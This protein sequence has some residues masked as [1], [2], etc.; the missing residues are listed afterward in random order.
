VAFVLPCDANK[1]AS[2]YHNGVL[3]VQGT[4]ANASGVAGNLDVWA[5]SSAVPGMFAEIFGF[6]SWTRAL[7]PEEIR[8]LSA[9]TW[10]LLGKTQ[11]F[12]YAP[13]MAYRHA[14]IASNSS[15]AAAGFRGT[16]RSAVIAGAASMVAY[17]RPPSAPER[18]LLIRPESRSVS[19]T[20]ESRVLIVRSE[21]RGIEA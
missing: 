20:E 16:P 6:V 19:P 9:G 10:V 12:W 11:R 14:Q 21:N 4:L 15:L 18:T 13:L 17:R 5:L 8:E 2:V 7:Y 3:A 1:T